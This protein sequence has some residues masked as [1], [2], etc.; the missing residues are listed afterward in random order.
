MQFA[1]A[2]APATPP[3]GTVELYSRAQRLRGKSAAG[4]EFDLFNIL[5]SLFVNGAE[6]TQGARIEGRTFTTT[7]SDFTLTFQHVYVDAP[8]IAVL[9]FVA[10]ESHPTFAEASSVSTTQAVIKT[11]RARN[12]AVLLGGVVN[13]TERVAAFCHAIILGVRA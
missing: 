7:T 2:A 5:E 12:Q 8:I 11:W 3:A 9:P 10:Q 13:P 6:Q 1:D 4:R